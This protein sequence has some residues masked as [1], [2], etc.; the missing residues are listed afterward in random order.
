M[1]LV[2]RF[3]GKLSSSAYIFSKNQEGNTNQDEIKFVE[4]WASIL[5]YLP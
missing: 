1:G 5:G 4:E 3:G 2:R